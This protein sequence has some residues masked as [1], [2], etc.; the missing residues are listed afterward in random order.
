MSESIILDCDPGHDDA[1]ALILAAGHPNID[2]VGV[3]TVAGNQTIDK[4][5]RNT[6][7]VCTLAS[8]D[9]PV[10]RGAAGPLVRPQIV[11]PDIHG[12]SGL[13]GPVLPPPDRDLDPRHA[14]RFIIDEVMARPAGTLTLVPTGPLTNIALA[15]REEPRIV[16]RVKQVSLMGGAVARGNRTPV[17]EFNILADPEAAAI[18]F[19]AGWPITQA[20]LDVTHTVRA[21]PDVLATF[22]AIDTP[23]SQ[24]VVDSLTF[25]GAAYQRAQG[26]DAPPVH[27][28]VAVAAIADPSLITCRD[29]FVAVELTGTWTAGMTVTDFTGQLGHPT[30][31][32]V[33]TACQTDAFWAQVV[34]AVIALNAAAH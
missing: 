5:T 23:L 29:A 34:D 22:R 1:I 4:V 24:F 26:F 21:T 15:I 8:I 10:A 18:V 16:G 2:L 11:A 25:Y 31:T 33:I 19:G 27:D 12:A 28:P 20:G 7:S 6:L 30:N 32:R 14:V 13:E 3:T 17:A 9:V